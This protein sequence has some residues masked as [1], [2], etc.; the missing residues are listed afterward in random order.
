MRSN[1]HNPEGYLDLTAYG[2]I[3]GN[4][5]PGEI[6]K[7]ERKDNLIVD[8]LI[9]RNYGEFCTCLMVIDDCME[10]CISVKARP[11]NDMKRYVNPQMLHYTYNKKMQ[12][13]IKRIPEDEFLR[14]VE[15]VKKTLDL[16]SLL[17]VG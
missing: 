3:H 12:M 5:K 16:D 14:T 17:G 8:E 7:Y 4:P 9:I 2:A 15:I 6:W 11:G 10:N 13:F 1:K